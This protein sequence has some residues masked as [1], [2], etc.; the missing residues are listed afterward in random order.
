MISQH[1]AEYA[2]CLMYAAHTVIMILT[3]SV[4]ADGQEI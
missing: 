4:I 3:S 2:Y 1:H